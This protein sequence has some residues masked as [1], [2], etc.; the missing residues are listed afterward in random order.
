[1]IKIVH[2]RL[3]ISIILAVLVAG[4]FGGCSDPYST[5]RIER[6]QESLHRQA[7]GAATQSRHNAERLQEVGPVLEEWWER[8]SERFDDRSRR[9]GDYVW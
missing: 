6:R 7:E 2:K 9:V 5:Q 1:M 8:N 4:L 3:P